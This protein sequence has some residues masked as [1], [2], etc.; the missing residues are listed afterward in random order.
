[1]FQEEYK[2]AYDEIKAEKGCVNEIFARVE[3]KSVHKKKKI[4]WKPVIVICMVIVSLFI[5]VSISPYAKTAKMALN[6]YEAGFIDYTS[7]KSLQRNYPEFNNGFIP[8]N[9]TVSRNG[10][11][12]KVEAVAFY[13]R[14]MVIIFSFANEEGHNFIQKD[15][16]YHWNEIKV[17]LDG[18]KVDFGYTEFGK[19]DAEKGK[20]YFVYT[21]QRDTERKPVG[22]MVNVSVRGCF[23]VDRWEEFYSTSDFA[24]E[25]DT[26]VVKLHSSYVD[27]G[28]LNSLPSYVDK[29]IVKL[30]NDDYP[31]MASVLD[32][33]PLSEIKAGEARITGAAYID[34]ILRVQICQSANTVDDEFFQRAYV[35]RNDESGEQILPNPIGQIVWYE[36]IDGEL[37]EFREEYYAVSEET[38]REFPLV[39]EVLEERGYSDTVWDVEFVV[40]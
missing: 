30:E 15:G 11:I 27:E 36:K 12:M 13:N 26:R 33:T 32:M 18:E 37:V 8:E 17:S 34:D 3:E 10:I 28:I 6:L 2:K 7:Y 1:M 20:T 39:L 14:E 35:V 31:Y 22:E 4:Q 38:A 19:F 21:A 16:D 40:E 5:G 25:A 23:T 24:L 9:A 29:D